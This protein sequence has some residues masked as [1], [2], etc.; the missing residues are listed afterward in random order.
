MKKALLI[1][2]F[3]VPVISFGQSNIVQSAANALGYYEKGTTT[4][5]EA[6]ELEKTKK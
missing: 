2:M 4:D 5:P 1:V 6:C 3:L